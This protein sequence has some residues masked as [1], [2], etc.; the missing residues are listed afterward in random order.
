MEEERRIRL[1]E[2]IRRELRL[3]ET[4]RI[5]IEIEEIEEIRDK[6]IEELKELSI[7]RIKIKKKLTELEDELKKQN[8]ITITGIKEQLLTE[9][10]KAIDNGRTKNKLAIMHAL[11]DIDTAEGAIIKASLL[12]MRLLK[13]NLRVGFKSIKL[14]T[15]PKGYTGHHI[16]DSVV[17]PIPTDVHRACLLPNREKHREKVMR[18]LRKNNRTLYGLSRFVIDEER[19]E[20]CE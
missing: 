18:W 14:L 16:T 11:D 8:K 1:K 13:R 15:I 20:L 4:G 2:R 9:L 17:V 12:V 3:R 19:K 5:D 10:N 7:E 6:S